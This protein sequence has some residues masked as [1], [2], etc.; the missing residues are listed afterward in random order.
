MAEIKIDPVVGPRLLETITSALYEDPIIIFREY[1]QNSVDA[2]NMAI[3]E[4]PA[5]KLKSFFVDIKIDGKRRNIHILDNGY[6]IPEDEF[7]AQMTNI[8]SSVKGKFKDQIGFRG[9]G[10]LSA[11]P[12]CKRLKFTNKPQGLNKLQNFIWDGD[13]FHEILNE[14]EDADFSSIIDVSEGK[15]LGDVADHFFKVEIQGYKEGISEVVVSDDFKNRLSIMLPLKYSA[16]FTHQ[17]EIKIKYEEYMGQSL[18][19]F[20]FV[21]KLD[22]KIL[23]KPYTDKDVLE[24]GI[25]FWELKNPSKRKGISGERIG[26]LWFS[27]NRLITARK[28]GEASGILV[29]SKNMLMGNQYSLATAIIRSK[30]D[31]VTTPR[32]L[33]QTL[34]GVTGEMLIHSVRLNDNARRDWFKIDEESIPLRHIIV[35]F[36]RRLRA[37]RYAASG[38][39]RDKTNKEKLTKAYIDLTNFDSEKFVSDINRIKEEINADREVFEYADEDIPIFPITIKRFYE[40]LIKCLYN[41]FDNKK[42]LEEF[43]RIR[44]FIKKDLNKEQKS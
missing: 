38:F 17:K 28:K 27:F 43:I 30:S 33:Y 19:R 21:V 2:Y 34:D 22:N 35:D 39:F 7:L 1:V 40:R 24:S 12:L 20:S 23:Y 37:Y 29:R 10:R 5:N 14:G 26:I 42:K 15:Y 18:D 9:I 4:D 41:Y 44:T 32:E 36:M 8:G 13:K 16:E 25:V 11:M 6:G 3:D 31:Y